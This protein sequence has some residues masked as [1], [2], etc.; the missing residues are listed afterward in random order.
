MVEELTS[1]GINAPLIR[2]AEEKSIEK[3]RIAAK[4][5]RHGRSKLSVFLEFLSWRLVF[6]IVWFP[7]QWLLRRASLV[8]AQLMLTEE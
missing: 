7:F 1:W 5:T 3:Q 4:A 6:M 2:L 8:A